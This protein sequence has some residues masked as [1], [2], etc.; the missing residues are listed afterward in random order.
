MK[1]FFAFFSVLLFILYG[2]KN[3]ISESPKSD[4]N[5]LATIEL[6]AGT[7]SPNFQPNISNYSVTVPNSITEITIKGITASSKALVS[8]PISQANL[9][10]GVSYTGSLT[11]TAESGN[12]KVYRFYISRNY[13]EPDISL[14]STQITNT[15]QS[16]TLPSAFYTQKTQLQNRA[17][18]EI[19]SL[20]DLYNVGAI[21][22]TTYSNEVA[23]TNAQL[24]L[25]IKALETQYHET[26]IYGNTTINYK[27]TN[28]NPVSVSVLVYFKIVANDSSE[29]QDYA[30][31]LNIP[32]NGFLDKTFY[33]STLGKKLQSISVT[34][35]SRY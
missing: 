7:I 28:T 6:S 15:S 23:K 19:K 20:Q 35:I 18:S 25:G 30:T 33:M 9:T 16:Y 17:A 2:C 27:V 14:V 12:I 26:N 3:P 22:A 32:S 31:V 21:T 4:D 10:T 29:F 24:A 5:T 11:V 13:L 8:S 1:R 34:K